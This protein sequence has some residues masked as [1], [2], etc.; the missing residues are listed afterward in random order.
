MAKENRRQNEM[1]FYKGIPFLQPNEDNPQQ[2]IHC[3]SRCV[4]VVK[5]L[6]R[7]FRCSNGHTF[8]VVDYRRAKHQ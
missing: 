3:P 1:E 7:T 5:K 4:K 2:C 8:T 6:P